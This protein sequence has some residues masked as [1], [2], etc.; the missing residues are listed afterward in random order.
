M[1]NV[2]PSTALRSQQPEVKR[3]ASIQPVIITDNNRQQYVFC[4]EDVFH[5]RLEHETQ[6][7]AYATRMAWGIRRAKD[8]IANG[9]FVVGADAAIRAAAE[10]R[11]GHG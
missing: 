7:A 3:A 2:F 6:E 1:Q 4:S 5:K 11:D 9:H 8:G 10:L